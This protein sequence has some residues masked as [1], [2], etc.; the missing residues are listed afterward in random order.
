MDHREDLLMGWSGACSESE[1]G[2]Y[3][4]RETDRRGAPCP[5]VVSLVRV[6]C[7][8]PRMH[9]TCGSRQHLHP[10]RHGH[11]LKRAISHPA[12]PFREP[13]RP[14]QAARRDR[15]S[16]GRTGQRL[17]H[18][19]RRC[20]EAPLPG[21]GMSRDTAPPRPGPSLWPHVRRS[22]YCTILS[23]GLTCH[24]MPSVP[25]GT[26]CSRFLRQ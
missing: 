14:R 16:S 26:S 22:L 17:R 25:G 7:P 18:P 20:H 5:N 3:R 6:S 23:G 12:S 11:Q 15:R 8:P 2:R 24:A 19:L 4:K 9:L 10:R 13:F 21:R 1:H